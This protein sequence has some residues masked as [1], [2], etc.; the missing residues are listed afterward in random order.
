MRLYMKQKVF[1]WGDKFKIYDEFENI[2]YLVEGEIF[3]WGKKLHVYDRAGREVAFI[4]EKVFSFL[5]K[6]YISHD[7]IDVAEVIKEFTFL[8]QRYRVNGPGWNVSGDFWAHEYEITDGSQVVASVSKRWFT[9]GD[10]Y[11]I[12]I[13]DCI[14]PDNE[15]E[16]AMVLCVVLVIDAVLDS[17]AGSAAAS[18]G[19]N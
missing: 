12:D 14:D 11:E 9:W 15:A 10:T 13:H 7:G 5:P 19:S 18:S 17:S 8:T 1:S 2:C 6:Y 4:H 16:M 3:T